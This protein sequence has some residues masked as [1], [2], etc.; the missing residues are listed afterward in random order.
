MMF[1][2]EMS[3][4]LWINFNQS[5][6]KLQMRGLG[7]KSWKNSFWQKQGKNIITKNLK[8]KIFLKKPHILKNPKNSHIFSQKFKEKISKFFILSIFR[9]SFWTFFQTISIKIKI[10]E[11]N[12]RRRKK[13]KMNE[14]YFCDNELM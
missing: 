13:R 14:F 8:N 10:P 2:K 3:R 4:K 7:W 1:E 12:F 9:N 5:L 6:Q 11:E